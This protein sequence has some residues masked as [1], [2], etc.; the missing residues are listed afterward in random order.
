MKSC[1]CVDF[2]QSAKGILACKV[3]R[4]EY[5]HFGGQINSMKGVIPQGA[6]FPPKERGGKDKTG[7]LK[8]YRVVFL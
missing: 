6:E 2:R 8:W 5:V 1:F 4:M 3:Y 7:F